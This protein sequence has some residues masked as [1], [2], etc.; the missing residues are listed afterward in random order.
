MKQLLLLLFVGLSDVNSQA[1]RYS[2]NEP[3]WEIVFGNN[4]FNFDGSSKIDSVAPCRIVL[5]LN[6]GWVVMNDDTIFRDVEFAKSI[7]F[8]F[9]ANNQNMWKRLEDCSLELYRLKYNV[10]KL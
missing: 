4:N 10:K 8:I 6:C 5:D 1:L 3:Q 7:Y 9:S 2:D